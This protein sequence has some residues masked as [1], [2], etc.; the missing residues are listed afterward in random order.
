[1]AGS[2]KWFV[3]TTDQGDDFALLADESNTEALNGAT[4]DF[5]PGLTLRYAV[6]RNIEPR[7]AV[8]TNLEGT[9]TIR[10]YALTQS[11]YNN[12]ANN[13][14]TIDD[15]ITQGGTLALARLEPERIR[16]LPIAAD[17]GLDDGD[18]T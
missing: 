1:M 14:Q 13:A 15:P 9:R 10:C 16:L 12:I 18:A 4:Q 6:P 11:I 7:A 5:V 2:K 3:Y 17:T 8:Y